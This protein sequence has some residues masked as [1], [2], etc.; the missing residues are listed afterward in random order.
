MQ[1]IVVNQLGEIISQPHQWAIGLDRM[2]ILGLVK[3]PHFGRGHY[4]TSCIKRL[5][6]VMHGWDI[7]LDKPVPLTIEIITQITGLPNRGMDPVLILDD[8]SKEKALTEE[9][10]KKY[11]T[12]RGKRGIIIKQINNVATQLG[13]NILAYKLLRKCRKDEVPVGVIAVTAQCEKGTFVSFSHYLM[14]LFQVDYKY[15]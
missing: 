12:T 9:M 6:V 10:N 2:S 1:N 14:N 4:A 13:T 3:L 7:W 8:K 11:G 15:A 5:L